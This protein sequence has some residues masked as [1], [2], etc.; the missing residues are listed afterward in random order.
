MT[1]YSPDIKGLHHNAYR[2]RDSEETRRFYEG[3]LGLR[4]ASALELSATKTG[5]PIKA[6]HTFFEMGDHSFLAFFE[7]IGDER[8]GMFEPKSD[9]DLHIALELPDVLTMMTYKEKAVAAGVE[10][11][12][13]SDHGTIQSIY[14]RDPNGYVIELTTRVKSDEKSIERGLLEARGIVDRWQ[15]NKYASPTPG[16]LN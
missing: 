5:R 16:T 9:F 15:H 12:G 11:R 14:L 8:E 10:V 3:L 13:P 7:V 1:D 6:L 4:L 2:C